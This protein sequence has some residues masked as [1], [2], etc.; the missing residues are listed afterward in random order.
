MLRQQH[1]LVIQ[2]HM[3]PRKKIVTMQDL[4]RGEKNLSSVCHGDRKAANFSSA[5]CTGEA[6]KNTETGFKWWFP[7]CP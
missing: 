6:G 2:L 5:A 7:V 3:L 1:K 4:Q